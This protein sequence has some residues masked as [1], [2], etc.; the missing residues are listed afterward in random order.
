MPFQ[1]PPE[2]LAARIVKTPVMPAKRRASAMIAALFEELGPN[3]S[4]TLR[5]ILD[6]RQPRDFVAAV[7]AH[8]PFLAAIARLDPMALQE[9]LLADPSVLLAARCAEARASIATAAG[10]TSVG[11]TLRDFKKKIALLVALADI[12]GIWTLEDVTGALSMAA[13][14]AVAET[15]RSLLKEAV[16]LGRFSPEDPENPEI[17]S[18]FIV[19]AMGKHGANELNYSSDIDL[20]IFFDPDR[21]PLTAGTEPMPFFVRLTQRLARILQER[22]ADG[23]VFRVDLRLRP[24]PGTTAVAVSVSAALD[25]Y[26]T[27][28]QTW[29]RAAF[30]KARPCAG[31]IDAADAFLA[32]LRPFV[33]RKFLD[34]GAIAD[35]H[36]MKLAMDVFRGHEAIAVEGHDVKLGRGGIREIEFFVQSQQ[37]IAG[38]RNPALRLRGTVPA[39]TALV[40]AGW[41]SEQV[42]DRLASAY[43]FLRMVEHRIQMIADEQ[44]HRLPKSEAGVDELARFLGYPNQTAF[45]TAFIA[46]LEAVADVYRRLFLERPGE[47]RDDMALDFAADPPKAATISRLIDLGFADPPLA[48]RTIRS[49]V[50]VERG[51]LR[52][53]EARAKCELLAPSLVAALGRVGEPD[54]ALMAFDALLRRHAQPVELLTLLIEHPGVLELV[55]TILGVAPR[56]SGLIGRR[57]HVLDTV[58]DPDFLVARADPVDMDRL[59]DAPLPR[60]ARFEDVLDRARVFGQEQLFLA[61]VRVLSGS[62][63]PMDAGPFFS[64]LASFLV[65]R[66]HRETET[67]MIAA[68]GRVPG[69]RTAVVALGKLGSGEMT[70]G[71][72][73]D[74]VLLYDH[75]PDEIASDGPRP[76]MG[77]QYFA[78]LTQRLISGLTSPTSE[79]RLYDVDLRLRPSGRNGPIASHIDGFASYQA[80]EAWTWEHMA[81]TRARVVVATEGFGPVVEAAIRDALRRA[82]DPVKTRAD[83]VEM[84][85]MISN[86][87]GEGDFWDL[88]YAAGGIIDLEFIAQT[89]QLLHAR[90]HPSILKGEPIAVIEVARDLEIITPGMAERVIAAATLYRTLDQLTRLC[91]EERFDPRTATAGLK[92]L[93]VRAA[94]LP[95]FSSLEAHLRATQAAT[96]EIFL[97]IVQA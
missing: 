6:I 14:L 49:W 37:L 52:A 55:A 90:R 20:N 62:L 26:E 97:D 45:A 40:E 95:D 79:G 91:L 3:E 28:G 15:V 76:L 50:R 25:Y 72:D 64:N 35:I 54:A 48:A 73:L 33:W 30:I 68:H 58:L 86:E 78:R 5:A 16:G 36:E 43:R 63:P 10:D 42:R 60:A 7:F 66:L 39:L 1:L 70:A 69:M 44:T 4:G 89:L 67:A 85:K 41:V 93:L 17:G 84:R 29:E 34:Y 31:D 80:T 53:R 82:R 56:L 22:T 8:S 32:E 61:G 77:S 38:G 65:R 88:K 75:A 19:L 71:S 47:R 21:A 46:D 51:G 87:K 81:L 27:R 13:D 83:I 92:R 59:F 57:A 94:E 74:L 24:D 9:T 2:S 18:G 23:Y 12:A 11:A 96:R